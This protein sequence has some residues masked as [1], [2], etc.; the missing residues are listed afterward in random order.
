MSHCHWYIDGGDF[1]IP[2]CDVSEEL[3]DDKDF[4]VPIIVCFQDDLVIIIESIGIE[5][6][7]QGVMD[8][9]RVV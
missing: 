4:L 2:S 7:I 8:H 3:F 1:C 6:S 9:I 5:F